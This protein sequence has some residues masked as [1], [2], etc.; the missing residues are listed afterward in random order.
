MTRNPNQIATP[1][2]DSRFPFPIRFEIQT[3][4]ALAALGAVLMATNPWFTAVDDEVVIID[5]AARPLRQTIKLFLGGGGQHEHPPLSDLVLHEWLWLTNGNLHW[6][7][8]PSVVFYLLGVWLLVQTARRLGG[9]RAGTCTLVL[10]LFWPY[11]FH[12]GAQ[13]AGTRSPSC[14]SLCLR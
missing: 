4:L 3:A 10:L 14:W 7:R 9:D 13:Q 2:R 6:L 11:G 12:T 8:L 1:S 5:V